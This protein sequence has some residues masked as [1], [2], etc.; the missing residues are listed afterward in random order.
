LPKNEALSINI[1]INNDN[2]EIK[3]YYFDNGIPQTAKPNKKALGLDI[4]NLLIAQLKATI[5]YNP[6]NIFEYYL[7]IPLNIE[8]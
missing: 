3:V 4:I 2:S 1:E 8:K 7:T 5:T 6:E